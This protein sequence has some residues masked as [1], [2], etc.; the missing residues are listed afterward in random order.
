MVDSILFSVLITAVTASCAMLF[1]N[2][3]SIWYQ[4]LVKPSFQPPAFVFIIGWSLIYLLF[5]ISFSVVLY[6]KAGKKACFMYAL[7]CIFNIL[8]C[9]LFFFLHM[10]LLA[11]PVLLAYLVTTYLTVRTVFGINKNAAYL[12]LV[13]VLWLTF[14]AVLNYTVIL[15][16]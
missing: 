7:Q 4:S 3:K 16:N 2:T 9:F 5:A 12:L 15:L 1:T 8:W 6:F 10:P 13:Q 11:F 14:A